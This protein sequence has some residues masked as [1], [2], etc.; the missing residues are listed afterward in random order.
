MVTEE[1]VREILN[2]VKDPHIHKT[3]EET[4]AIESI[5]IKEEKITSVSRLP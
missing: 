5:K 4:G 2:P 1:R 3:F